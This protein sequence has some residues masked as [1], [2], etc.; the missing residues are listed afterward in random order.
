MSAAERHDQR[1]LL[2]TQ[3]DAWRAWL[4]EHRD[5]PVVTAGWSRIGRH[6][7]GGAG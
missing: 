1:R 4:A 7:S 3:L 6:L 2:Q 5:D